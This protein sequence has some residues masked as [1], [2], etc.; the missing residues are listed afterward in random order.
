MRKRESRRW[1]KRFCLEKNGTMKL[2]FA[3]LEKN[4]RDTG[5]VGV[6]WKFGFGSGNIETTR[7]RCGR[8]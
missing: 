3:E 2:T 5:L 7:W 4:M 8:H 1:L 6:N